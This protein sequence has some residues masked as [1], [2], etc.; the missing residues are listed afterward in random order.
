MS[1]HQRLRRSGRRRS[2]GGRCAGHSCSGLGRG[3]RRHSRRS[4]RCSGRRRRDRRRPGRAG[5]RRG[6]SRRRFR[7]VARPKVSS[8]YPAALALELDLPPGQITRLTGAV[9]DPD[10]APC[11]EIDDNR[12]VGTRLCSA[13]EGDSPRCLYL[14][15]VADA[16][17]R[18]RS[19]CS[20][21]AR[22][23]GRP[24]CS[25]W[26]RR[27]GRPSCSGWAPCFGRSLRSCRPLRSCRALRFGRS[28]CFRRSARSRRA[29]RSRARLARRRSA[30]GC[31]G[32]RRCR[33]RRACRGP[34][35]SAHQQEARQDS[36]RSPSI[37]SM[38]YHAPRIPDCEPGLPGRR[39]STPGVHDKPKI[40][41]LHSTAIVPAHR[42]ESV[43]WPRLLSEV[44]TRR[45][46]GAT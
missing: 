40:V 27:F 46:A 14:R 41:Q 17:H 10:Q 1:I 15:I 26:A 34:A 31:R 3:C 32:L 33:G 13:T 21:W 4:V 39:S 30:A 11:R 37:D 43:W 29:A 8:C 12:L 6:R 7:R 22:R 16:Q 36:C 24:S 19:R 45:E 2:R 25:G 35:A 38:S 9:D 18:S 20:G 42:D 28:S 44:G 23:L 5:R